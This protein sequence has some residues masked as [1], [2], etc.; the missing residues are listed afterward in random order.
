MISP[1]LLPLCWIIYL[2]SKNKQTKK[3]QKTT[4]NKNKKNYPGFLFFHM[5]L[6]IV[7]LNSV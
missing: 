4:T 7:L 1:E 2:K 6:R 5:K 3:N